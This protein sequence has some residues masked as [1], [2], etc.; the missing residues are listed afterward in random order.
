VANEKSDP[1][2]SSPALLNPNGASSAGLSSPA[3]KA[4][5]AAQVIVISSV[6]FTFISYWRTAAVVLCDLASTAYYIGAIVESAIGKAA[7]WFIVGVLVFSYAMRA[8]YIESSALFVRGGVYRVVKEAM[9]GFVAKLS[10]SALLF[11]YILTGPISGVSAGQYIVGLGLD[12]LTDYLHVPMPVDLRQDIKNWGAVAIACVITLYFFRQNML[13]IH[14]S[15]DKALKIMIATTIMGLVILVWSGVTLA[16]QGAKEPV[17]SWH[18]DLNPKYTVTDTGEKVPKI[19]PITHRQEDPLGFLGRFPAIAEPLRNSGSASWLSLIGLIGIVIAF[20]HSILAM[21]GEET[22]AQV[23]R[24]VESPKLK[25]FKKAAFIVFVYSLLL[26]GTVSFLAMILMTEKERM[27]KYYDNLIGGLAMQMVGPV[28]LTLLL[29]AF[30]VGVGF[31]IL[32]GA[33]NT[34]IIGSNGVLNRVAEDGVLPDWFL[35]PHWRYGTSSR[36]LWLIVGLQLFTIIASRGDFIL[37]GEAYA[38]GVVWS[39]TFKT[40][41]MVVLR[42]K[43]HTPREFKVP[44]NIHIGKIEIPVGL[45]LIALV[46]LLSAIANLLTKE[47]ATMSG[48]AFSAI[49]LTIF[50]TTESVNERRRGTKHVHL[51]QFNQQVLPEIKSESLALTKPYRKLV[52]IRSPHNLFMLEKALAESDPNT[53]D[54][55]VMT[56]KVTVPGGETGTGRLDLDTYDQQLMTA[57]VDRAERAGKKVRPLIVPTNSPLHAIL[58][59][60]KEIKAQE[61]VVGAS[62]KFSAEEQ[63]DQIAFYWISL[64][65][66]RPPGLTVRVLSRDRDVYFDVEGGNRIPKFG[67]RHARNVADLRAAGLGVHKVLLIHDATSMSTDLFFWVLTMLDPKVVLDIVAIPPP[68][69]SAAQ[70]DGVL[71]KDQERARSLGREIRVQSLSG[72]YGSDVVRLARDGHYE[73]IIVPLSQERPFEKGRLCDPEM[74]Y[75][76]SHAHC[77][78]F[79]AAHP[80]I[81]AEVVD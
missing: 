45:G 67:E 78:V 9:G 52:A 11:D 59:V 15:S 76:L 81:P 4:I 72:N 14:E 66:G 79:L 41:S 30:V 49:F 16:V 50:M 55:V 5:R 64:H 21:S 19:N 68:E 73:L 10:V 48:A 51:E 7:P 60:A 36:I 40:L 33:V 61:V 22:L 34:S 54:V 17:P 23:Y 26:T 8:V 69:D 28:W 80:V 58:R 1:A 3:A 27:G 44:F 42:F 75:V 74:S 63:L 43:D 53:T 37:L 31:L 20:G 38:F 29:N 56:A 65:D 47:V 46:V 12:A 57:V 77:P 6:T 25:N 71:Q 32:S 13:G 2:S 70:G 35:K 62:N 24:E 39:F 18:P